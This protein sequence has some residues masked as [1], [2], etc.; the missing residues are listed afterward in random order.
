[1]AGAIENAFEARWCG[2]ARVRAD[3]LPIGLGGSC[4]PPRSMSAVSVMV[5]KVFRPLV[6]P[7]KSLVPRWPPGLLRI[8]RCTRPKR[9]GIGF[10]V[11][12]QVL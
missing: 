9:G 1:M 5:A 2:C 8:A 11:C 12:L 7:K 3:G 4:C 6:G 10:G